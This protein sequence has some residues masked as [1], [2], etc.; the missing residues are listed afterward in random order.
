[1]V[2]CVQPIN[3]RNSASFGNSSIPSANEISGGFPDIPKGYEAPESHGMQLDSFDSGKKAIGN[4]AN[5]WINFSETAG[6]VVKGAV[7]AGLS[8]AAV[9]LVNMAIVFGS[10]VAHGFS[11]ENPLK[12]KFMSTKGKVLA[13]A[14]AGVV[15]AANLINAYLNANQRKANVEHLLNLGHKNEISPFV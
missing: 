8:G 9:S 1:M 15:F 10:K 12:G 11:K 7:L 3:H 14:T 13:F 2:V 6:G 4:V 5:G